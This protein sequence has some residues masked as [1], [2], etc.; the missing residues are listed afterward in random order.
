MTSPPG[1]T[2]PR[3]MA[4]TRTGRGRR[5]PGTLLHTITYAFVLLAGI[6]FYVWQHVQVV[7][8][9]YVIEHLKGERATL[10]QRHRELTLE[11]A[12]LKSLK[13][14]EERAHRDLGLRRAE[15]SQIVIVK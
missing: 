3:L 8:L 11:I 9:G 1:D 2:P 14:V 5:R 15:P 10:L 7:R 13:Q 12:S 6:L 4:G